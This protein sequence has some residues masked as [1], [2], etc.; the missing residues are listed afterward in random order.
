MVELPVAPELQEY[1]VAPFAVNVTD[2][3][4]QIVGELTLTIGTGFTITVAT[5][6]LVQPAIV[7][8]VTL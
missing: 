2:C 7:L 1:A 5:A 3:P 8:P 6:V 4:L